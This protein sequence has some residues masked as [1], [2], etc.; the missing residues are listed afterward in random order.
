ME[1]NVGMESW[2]VLLVWV[3][4]GLVGVVL[5]CPVWCPTDVAHLLDMADDYSLPGLVL[6]SVWCHANVTHLPG[7]DK[8]RDRYAVSLGWY[9]VWLFV[10][11]YMH[12]LIRSYHQW[13]LCFL[14]KPSDIPIVWDTKKQNDF[15]YSSIEVE[16]CSM[17]TTTCE[18]TSFM[19]R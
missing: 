4:P 11:M 9:G 15:S 17:A 13:T 14:I 16:Y 5:V 1:Q 8:L 19:T 6:L 18:L 7:M 2:S 10:S 12:I 3:S